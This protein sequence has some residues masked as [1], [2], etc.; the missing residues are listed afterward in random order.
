MSEIVID[1]SW[2]EINSLTWKAALKAPQ[3]ARHIR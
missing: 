3:E 2:F 1:W